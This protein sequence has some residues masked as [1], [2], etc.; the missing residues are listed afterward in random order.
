MDKSVGY[1]YILTS[2]KT[3]CI[4]IGGTDYPP[5]KRI[6][7]INTTEPYKSLGPWSIA[8]FRQVNDWRKVEHNLHYTFRSNLD[9]SI[10]QQK[11]LFHVP[12][13]D[14]SKKLDEIDPEQIVHKPKIDRMFQDENF[15]NYVINLF[16]FTGL[17]NWLNL[18]GAWTFVLFPSTSGGRY[19]TINIGSHEVAFSTLGRKDLK[20]QNMIL[21]DRLIFD[22]GQVINWIMRHNGTI[23]VDHYATALPR[24]TSI[25]FEGSFDDVN[26]FLSLDGVRRALI[27]Y[28]NEALIK[29]KEK[30]TSSVYAR[31][32]NWNAVA[33]LHHRIENME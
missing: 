4:K 12:I 30:N 33:K 17:M 32:H 14:A 31:Y 26:E 16:V 15:L 1:I 27:A 10:G 8:D 28:W 7:E 2:P 21:V 20:Q 23:E 3:D 6:K 24:S 13:Q 29:M 5:L 11:E 25:I 22:F 18:Q 9:T 19:F